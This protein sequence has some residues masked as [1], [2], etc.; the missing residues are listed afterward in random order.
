VV[1]ELETMPAPEKGGLMARKILTDAEYKKVS[2]AA[3]TV[4]G[5]AGVG[6]LVSD[7]AVTAILAAVDTLTPPPA[8]D[9]EV[10]TA[11]FADP[12]GYWWQCQDD[13]DHSGDNHDGGDWGWSDSDPDADTIPPRKGDDG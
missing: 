3:F 6:S 9:P 7:D 12:S 4:L 5:R 8:P 11:M 13:P 10:C 2:A 1:T